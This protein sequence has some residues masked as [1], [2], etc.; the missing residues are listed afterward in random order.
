MRGLDSLQGDADRWAECRAVQRPVPPELA[1]SLLFHGGGWGGSCL[2]P[3]CGVPIL[4]MTQL[5]SRNTQ[6]DRSGG[7]SRA[8]SCRHRKAMLKPTVKDTQ[9]KEQEGRRLCQAHTS[10]APMAHP[11]EPRGL[12]VGGTAS[13]EMRLGGPESPPDQSTLRANIKPSPGSCW[14]LLLFSRVSQSCLRVG[15]SLH[16]SSF[17]SFLFS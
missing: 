9:R 4:R 2:M 7:L 5:S 10:A 16:L 14:F 12:L 13:P 6:A 17:P 15:P 3:W 11:E 1:G 8:G